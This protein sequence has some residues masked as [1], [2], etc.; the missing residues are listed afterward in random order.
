MQIHMCTH[1][2]KLPLKKLKIFLILNLEDCKYFEEMRHNKQEL[3][4]KIPFGRISACKYFSVF[5]KTNFNTEIVSG[6]C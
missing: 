1:T 4:L 5:L 6:L 2:L 3:Y